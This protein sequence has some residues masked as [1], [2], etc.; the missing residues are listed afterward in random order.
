[1]KNKQTE[2]QKYLDNASSSWIPNLKVSQLQIK[3]KRRCSSLKF[4]INC[5]ME[6]QFQQH[7]KGTTLGGHELTKIKTT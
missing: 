7:Q 2:T 5:G 4:V 6:K 3:M 1:M